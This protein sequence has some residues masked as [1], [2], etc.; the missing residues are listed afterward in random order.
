MELIKIAGEQGL[1]QDNQ[2][3]AILGMPPIEGGERYTQ[4]L[5]YVDKSL[6]NEYQMKRAGAPKVSAEPE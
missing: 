1:L 3:L 5:N 4:S 6:I 2:K